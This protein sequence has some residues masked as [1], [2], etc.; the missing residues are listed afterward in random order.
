[1]KASVLELSLLL[2]ARRG[3]PV[4]PGVESGDRSSRSSRANAYSS[5]AGATHRGDD[6]RRL[7]T[8][9]WTSSKLACEVRGYDPSPQLLACPGAQAPSPPASAALSASVPIDPHTLV[10][11]QLYP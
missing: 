5:E 10:R 1:V 4:A 3:L 2:R 6:P 11:Y 7:S 9:E 8:Q